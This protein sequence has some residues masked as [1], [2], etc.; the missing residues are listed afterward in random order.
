MTIV[1]RPDP[2]VWDGTFANNAWLQECPKPLTKQV[3]GNAL[4]LNPRGGRT[5]WPRPPA[6]SSRS[7][8]TAGRS[9]RRSVSSPAC[10]AAWSASRSG[11][12]RRNAGA[13][14]TASAPTPSRSGPRHSPWTDRRASTIAKTGRRDEI[15]LPP[16]TSFAPEDVARALSSARALQSGQTEGAFHASPVRACCRSRPASRRWPRLG[17]GD[18]CLGLHRL[19]RL[20]GRLP[21]REQRAGGRPGEDRPRPRHALA[22][23]RRYDHGTAARPKPGFQP[24]PCMHCE[25]APCEPVCPVGASVHDS[26]GLNVQVYNRCVGTRFCEANCPYKVRR[27]NFFGYADGQEYAQ[28]RR[29][30]SCRRSNNPNVTVRARGVMEKCTYCVQR[31]SGARR[32][33]EKED[34]P[35]RDGEVTTACQSACPTRRSP[36]ATSPTRT[37]AVEPA[38]AEPQ[39][40]ALLGQ[41]EHPA[42]HD[43]SGRRA[44][45]RPRLRRGRDM[46][47]RAR[48]APARAASLDRLRTRA[49]TSRSRGDR[50]SGVRAG[51]AR[52]WWIALAVTLPFVAVVHRLDRLAVLSTASASGASTPPSSGASP[53]PTTSGGSASAMPAR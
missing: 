24:V 46:T 5:A 23:H 26:E 52:R 13:I 14:G 17:H 53:S 48:P 11:Y 29:P 2:T 30:K 27:F 38:E 43:L 32:E 33:A 34:R 25:T 50:R 31:I 16:R 20:R 47:S 28:S 42:A 35:M 37:A 44:Q 49:P 22:A 15:L 45:P 12:G 51:R 4:S 39:H 19:Q 6:M 7:P 18:R 21:G 9:R 40:Y 10:A 1:L 8:R 36:S 41:L 3:W